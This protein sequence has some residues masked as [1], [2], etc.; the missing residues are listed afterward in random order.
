MAAR[1]QLFHPAEVRQKIQASQLLNRLQNFALLEMDDEN[2]ARKMMTADQ[3]R[4]AFGLLAKVVPDQ[5]QVDADG[6]ATDKLQI[7]VRIGGE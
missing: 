4:A 2:A 1:K 3:V 5:K 6:D 7:L